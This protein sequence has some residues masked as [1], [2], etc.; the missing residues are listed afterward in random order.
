MAIWNRNKTKLNES[1]KLQEAS[2]LSQMDLIRLMGQPYYQFASQVTSIRQNN[3]LTSVVKESMLKDPIISRIINMW[4]SDTLS[5]DIISDKIFDVVITNNH[6]KKE[7][8]E[9]NKIIEDAKSAIDYL[10]ENSNIEDS[11]DKILY[12]IIIDG[13]ISV[14]LGFVDLYEDTKIKLFESNKRKANKLLET[15]TFT[16]ENKR[17]ELLEATT[18]DD[19]VND[20]MSYNMKTRIKSTRAIG[21]YYLEV[22]PQK[23]VPLKHKGITVLYLDLNNSL[24]VL[25]PRNITTFVN[26]RG[27]NKI[28]SIKENPED[29]ESTVYDLP[30]GMS[31]I[32][33]AVTP[34]SMYNTVQDCTLLAMLTRSAIYRLFQV[35][36]QALD[37]KET[38]ALLQEFKKRITSRETIDVRSEH[39]SSA[40]TQIPLGDSLIVPTRNGVGTINVQSIGGDLDVRTEEPLNFFRE[41]L[42]ASLG[43]S[44][45]LIY[46]S[47]GGSLVN[48]SATRSDIRYLRTIQQ[49]TSI[50]SL[51]LEDIF[52]DYLVMIGTDLSDI[53]VKVIFK[54]LNSEEALQKMEYEQTKQDSLNKVIE[55]LGNLGI[56][57]GNGKY[58]NLRD[59]L[60]KRYLD[61]TILDLIRQ[62]E[63]NQPQEPQLT[64]EEE[65]GEYD[66]EDTNI[67]AP[68]SNF[69]FGEDNEIPSD[70][71]MNPEDTE[72][73]ELPDIEDVEGE[74]SVEPNT[75]SNDNQVPYS[76]G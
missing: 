73:P 43:V 8:K 49:F 37:T 38:E 58:I 57:F 23:I 29:I 20:T 11:L 21:R 2:K 52:K 19:Y 18:Y 63:K 65:G 61:D 75:P 66:G 36:V 62:D 31:F 15:E 68:T 55:S 13:I 42:L 1:Q 71:E 17:K 44:K 47:E 3:N 26:T 24:K 53:T 40:Q 28:L 14:K 4:I 48:T 32:D 7:E 67:S 60:I 30:M 59:E 22:L 10:L 46:G 74:P 51:G 33:Q 70:E 72:L 50:L 34:W 76:V 9:I 56:E 6:S 39:Y 25:N 27:G 45:D 69:D 16:D 64:P 12:R 54:Q 41:E 35:E 5:R